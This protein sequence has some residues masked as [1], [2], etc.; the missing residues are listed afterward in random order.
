MNTMYE[1]NYKHMQGHSNITID[2]SLIELLN[3]DAN[4]YNGE[5]QL[6]CASN[7]LSSEHDVT[8]SV[9][10]S[11]SPLLTKTSPVTE[12]ATPSTTLQ[13]TS[14]LSSLLVYPKPP[15]KKSHQTLKCA[16]V[17]TRE[18]KEKKEEQELKEMRKKEREKKRLEREQ[19]KVRKQQQKEAKKKQQEN[20]ITQANKKDAEVQNN[21]SN[22]DNLCHTITRTAKRKRLEETE[23]NKSKKSKEDGLQHNEIS[24]NECAACFGTHEEDLNKAGE[25]IAEW[26]QCTNKNCGVWSHCDCLDKTKG[27]YVCAICQTMFH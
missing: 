8:L 27:E 12:V 9:E 22:V 6:Q 10:P 23:S 17:L 18:R 20:K 7:S 13:K 1:H 16:R 26:I 3:N 15:H 24:Q 4:N 5:H 2:I 11:E 14:P 19:D 21:T 25:L